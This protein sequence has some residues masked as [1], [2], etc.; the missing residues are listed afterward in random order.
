MPGILHCYYAKS[1]ESLALPNGNVFPPQLSLESQQ[2]QFKIRLTQPSVIHHLFQ[3]QFQ[4]VRNMLWFSH[5]L[6]TSKSCNPPFLWAQG[7]TES[8]SLGAG[9]WP[10]KIES[11]SQLE[12]MG[13]WRV[14]ELA[15]TTKTFYH[16]YGCERNHT[17]AHLAL[18]LHDWD[19]SRMLWQLTLPKLISLLPDVVLT[20]QSDSHKI[21]TSAEEA[22]YKS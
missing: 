9:A 14:A 10:P 22:E 5:L 1:M 20:C 17:I 21:V 11:D 16:K 8:A 2:N 6:S 3:L 13:L 19:V 15:Q 7:Y 18:S 4:A 12:W